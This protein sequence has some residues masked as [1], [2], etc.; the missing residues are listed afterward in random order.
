M[1]EIVDKYFN[2]TDETIDDLARLKSF[3]LDIPEVDIQHLIKQ[4]Y[5]AENTDW[6]ST[7]EVLEI[8]QKVFN[9]ERDPKEK[10]FILGEILTHNKN[11]YIK[12]LK[13]E[14]YYLQIK[15]KR[16][17]NYINKIIKAYTGAKNFYKKYQQDKAQEKKN[18]TDKTDEIAYK[19]AM[20]AYDKQYNIGEYVPDRPKKKIV[21]VRRKPR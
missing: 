9:S 17:R 16:Q 12:S 5:A 19:K 11:V 8:C 15:I 10:L 7:S 20:S 4:G 3:N 18:Y 1:E 6:N 2:P 21:K 13:K 14:F